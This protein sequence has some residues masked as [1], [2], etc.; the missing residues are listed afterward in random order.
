LPA[1]PHRDVDKREY[2][3]SH[4]PHPIPMLSFGV[5]FL[6]RKGAY[7]IGYILGEFRIAP[8]AKV[9][10]RKA[11]RHNA[12]LKKAMHYQPPETNLTEFWKS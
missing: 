7:A 10:Q 6:P 11:S 8:V 2:S 1:A 5:E 12:P 9:V 4:D 3:L